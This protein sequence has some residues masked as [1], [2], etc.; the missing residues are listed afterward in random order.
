[1]A[2]VTEAA[3]DDYEL[4]KLHAA[5]KP[6]SERA[7]RVAAAATASGSVLSLV[8]LV[9]G[10]GTI[11]AG[12]GL[13][14]AI[15]LAAAVA[16]AVGGWLA[17]SAPPVADADRGAITRERGELIRASLALGLRGHDAVLELARR[18]GGAAPG[19]EPLPNGDDDGSPRRPAILR[20]LVRSGPQGDESLE[21][22]ADAGTGGL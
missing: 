16:V 18:S 14:R 1:M 8:L 13:P 9:V 20:T 19:N 17:R 2:R 22:D 6:P 7:P 5:R 15:Q 12:D 10:A 4:T 3:L 11:L 21:P